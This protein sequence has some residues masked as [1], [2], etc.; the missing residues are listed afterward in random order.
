MGP[1]WFT[2]FGDR[3]PEW[4]IGFDGRRI[5]LAG[6]FAPSPLVDMLAVRAF[7]SGKGNRMEKGHRSK[8]DQTLHMPQRQKDPGKCFLG[9][10]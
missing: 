8:F 3:N 7:R 10:A 1:E 5:V 2:G 9:L 4:F 6:G